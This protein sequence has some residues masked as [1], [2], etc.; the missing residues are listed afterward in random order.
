MDRFDLLCG[1]GIRPRMIAG[2][3][4]THN[5][6]GFNPPLSSIVQETPVVPIDP[7]SIN[8]ADADVRGRKIPNAT[9]TTAVSEMNGRRHRGLMSLSCFLI[10]P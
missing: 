6:Q 3:A 7:P 1:Y 4:R 10:R 8:D 2:C 5:I 9:K